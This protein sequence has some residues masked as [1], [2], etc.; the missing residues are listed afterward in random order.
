MIRVRKVRLGAGRSGVEPFESNVI[1]RR[2]AKYGDMNAVIALLAAGVALWLRPWRSVGASGPPWLWFA[3]WSATPVLWGLDRYAQVSILPPMSGAALLVLLAGW[4]LA[5]IAMLP[6][7]LI[8]IVAGDLGGVEGLHRLVWLG[9]VPATMVLAIGAALRR[10]LPHHLFVYILGRGFFGTF[11]ASMLA[12][13]VAS[14]LD[15]GSPVV[16]ANNPLA[17]RLLVG[18]S[19][20]FL[21]GMVTASL[22]VFRP[23]CL[24]TYTDRLYLPR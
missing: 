23:Q 8:V 2:R 24:A 9:I 18:F 22:V 11:V 14:L 1:A 4:P 16:A 17:A 6:S 5:I 10:W 3:A 12:S 19:E 21:T 15:P 20:A 13:G 7:A